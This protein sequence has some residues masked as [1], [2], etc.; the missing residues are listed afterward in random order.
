MSRLVQNGSMMPSSNHGRHFGAAKVISHRH[1]KTDN[2]ANQRRQRRNREAFEEYRKIQPLGRAL[3]IVE[4]SR[5]FDA[6]R[7]DILAKTVQPNNRHRR[8]EEQGEP[9]DR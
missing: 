7:T 2:Q 1:G 4:C 9:E 8:D 5:N 6:G 3:V